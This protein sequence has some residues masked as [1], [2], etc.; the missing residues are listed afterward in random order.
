[1]AVSERPA[2]EKRYARGLLASDIAVV[3]LAVTA[4]Q[5]FRYGAAAEGFD[6]AADARREL[7]LR[8]TVLS[9]SVTTGWLLALSIFESRAPKAL[10][11]GPLEYKRVINATLATFGL[12]A[13]VAFAMKWQIGRGFLFIALPAGIV[14]LV[15]TRWAWR[16]RL[17]RQRI[18]GENSHRT[19]IVGEREKAAHVARQLTANPPAGFNVVGAVTATGAEPEILP[20]LPVVSDFSSIVEAVTETRADV[21]IVTGTDR[22]SPQRLREIGWELEPLEVDLVVTAALTDVAGPR[23]HMSPVSGLPLIHVE[24]PEFSGRSQLAKRIFDVVGS[25][26]LIVLGLPVFLAVAILVKSTSRGPI[27]YAQERIGRSGRPFRMLKFRSMVENADEQLQS[28]LDRQGTAGKP[29]HKIVD[30][31]RV[32]PVGRFLRRYS[33]DELPQLF[34]VFIGTM[35]LVGPRPQREAEVALYE[36]YDHRRLLVKPGITGLWQVS[37]RSAL[38]WEDAIRL[39]LYY[40]ENWSLTGDLVLLWK[41]LR[42]AIRQEGAW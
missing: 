31:P 24:Y 34:N 6:L 19:L 25:A 16:K 3:V 23:I 12:F 14:L 36:A 17:H 21:V 22:I 28:L 9:A 35:S 2:W 39:D 27:L 33:L 1:L 5:L 8:Y 38:Q 26:G 4:A 37:G 15:V 7:A 42:A 20:G 18:R 30:D 13:I 32:T 11:T 29:L 41:T 10:G 40:V